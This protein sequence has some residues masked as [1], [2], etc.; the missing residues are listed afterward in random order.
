MKYLV[1]VYFSNLLCL[2]IPFYVYR[3][4]NKL[5]H[6]TKIFS[7]KTGRKNYSFISNVIF[8]YGHI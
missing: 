5:N 8:R 2:W 1:T 6:I 3:K 7:T 4:K